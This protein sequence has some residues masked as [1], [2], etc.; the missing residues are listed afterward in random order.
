MKAE[1]IL[2]GYPSGTEFLIRETTVVDHNPGA[3]HLSSYE[4]NG[5]RR[6]PRLFRRREL[7]YVGD[8]NRASDLVDHAAHVLILDGQAA[9]EHEFALHGSIAKS[10]AKTA[11]DDTQ[12]V[13]IENMNDAVH[14]HVHAA[15]LLATGVASGVVR[16]EYEGLPCHAQ[17]DWLSPDR[18]IVELKL[19]ENLDWLAM[20]A[21]VHDTVHHLAFQ[22][23]LV[24]A[25][26]GHRHLVHLIAVE[27]REP[28]RCG[29]WRLGDE[30]LTHAEKENT[31]AIAR[32]R[33]C[34]RTGQWPTGYEGIRD[35][36]WI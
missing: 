5:F 34:R 19:C 4:L 26:S 11:L 7:G 29:V 20:D 15:A 8:G 28:F 17:L 27:Q 10:M 2:E 12:S 14:A 16:V 18:G 36:D 3:P 25:A 35:C 22:R 1:T 31:E 13:L 30:L 6:N 33:N 21:R 32:L 23:S 9:Y 24:E